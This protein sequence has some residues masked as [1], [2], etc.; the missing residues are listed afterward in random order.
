MVGTVGRKAGSIRDVRQRLLPDQ[1][2][3]AILNQW[4]EKLLIL[5]EEADGC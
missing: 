3:D 2:L 4:R 1:K 5:V